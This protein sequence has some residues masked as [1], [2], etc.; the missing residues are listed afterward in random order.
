[1][2]SEITLDSTDICNFAMQATVPDFPGINAPIVWRLV[3]SVLTGIQSRQVPFRIFH[4][5]LIKKKHRN[6]VPRPRSSSSTR[7]TQNMAEMSLDSKYVD[8]L[9]RRIQKLED[10]LRKARIPVSLFLCNAGSSHSM[11]SCNRT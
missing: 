9:E 7:S 1:M 3:R 5:I 2:N 6:G 4:G 10:M 8:M 11:H